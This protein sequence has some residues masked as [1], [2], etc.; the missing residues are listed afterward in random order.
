LK[1]TLLSEIAPAKTAYFTK[2]L[3]SINS[4]DINVDKVSRNRFA[5]VLKSRM[6]NLYIPSYTLRRLRLSQS[7]PSSIRLQEL[8]D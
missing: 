6:D 4:V 3:Y 1:S 8:L 5:A 2:S 7:P